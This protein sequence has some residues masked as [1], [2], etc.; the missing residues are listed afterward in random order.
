MPKIIENLESR[1][2]EEVKKQ[3]D[4]SG[5]DAIT[6][7][8]VASACGVGVGTVYNYFPS[9]ED[10]IAKHLL[11]D[12]KQCIDAIQ[13]A[14]AASD[15]PLPV[16]F[17]IY[18]QLLRFAR[19]HAAIFQDEA[20][21]ASFTSAFSRHHS[22]LRSQLAQ[23]LAKFCASDFTAEF[24]VEALLTWTM[25]LKPFDDIYGMIEKLF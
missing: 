22:V 21:A 11:D 24:I 14:A 23:F 12:W 19:S 8:S 6:I 10:L 7:R 15:T 3:L 25:A 18:D 13:A 9:K 20:A 5:Y 1:L 4:E 16:V 17:C 2:I